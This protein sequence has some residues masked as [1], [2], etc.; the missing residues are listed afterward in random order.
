MNT[1]KSARQRLAVGLIL[2]ALA[3]LPSPAVAGLFGPSDTRECVIELNKNLR[4]RPALSML[5][6]ACQV[7]YMDN[8]PDQIKKMGRAAKCVLSKVSEVYSAESA[9]ATVNRCTQA[10]SLAFQFFNGTLESS[11]QAAEPRRPPDIR[12]CI[13][14]GP[15]LDCR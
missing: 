1:P 4:Y 14:I 7:A 13:F 15:V 10:D 8:P 6:N 9:R 5:L 3:I 11:I 12:D 2:N